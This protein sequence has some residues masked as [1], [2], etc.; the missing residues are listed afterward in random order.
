MHLEHYTDHEENFHTT[1]LIEK[2]TLNPQLS[3]VRCDR[4]DTATDQI[5]SEDTPYGVLVSDKRDRTKDASG[6]HFNF[7]VCCSQV[8]M[9]LIRQN[10]VKLNYSLTKRLAMPMPVPMHILTTPSSCCCLSISGN[11]L[12]TCLAP[13][14]PSGW[15][16]AIP[17]PLG[18]TL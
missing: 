14:A 9:N 5:R 10:C 2:T 1:V 4:E 8:P 15:P 16:K 3:A 11:K 12:L 13:V 6:R 7:V 17:L 18:L